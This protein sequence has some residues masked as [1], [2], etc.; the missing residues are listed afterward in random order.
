VITSIAGAL[1]TAWIV[2]LVWLLIVAIRALRASLRARQQFDELGDFAEV[3]EGVT[4]MQAIRF[5]NAAGDGG[6]DHQPVMAFLG[7]DMPPEMFVMYERGGLVAPRRCQ[8]QRR[9]SDLREFRMQLD[10]YAHQC[11]CRFGRV[12]TMGLY[13]TAQ[14]AEREL[15]EL[16][17]AAQP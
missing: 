7:R 16:H 12:E 1:Y 2:A 6:E 8:R 9:Q 15:A 17:A 14:S 5:A 11:G 4:T 3:L 10:I 13:L